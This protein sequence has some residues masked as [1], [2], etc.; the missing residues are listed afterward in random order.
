MEFS[1]NFTIAAVV[2]FVGTMVVFSYIFKTTDLE[3]I[4]LLPGEEILFE[5]K[6]VKVEH[7]GVIKGAVFLNCLVRVTNMRLIIAQKGIFRESYFIRHVIDYSVPENSADKSK[8]NYFSAVVD[9]ERIRLEDE[10][11]KKGRTFVIVEIPYSSG[12]SGQ[13]IRFI[14]S[15]VDEFKNQFIYG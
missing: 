10:P 15:R 6:G 13:Y 3:N 8:K 14:T 4:D 1:I 5:E 11:G 9:R 7:G 12:M 2:I